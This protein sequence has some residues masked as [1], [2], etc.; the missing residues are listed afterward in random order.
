MKKLPLFGGGG[1][2]LV[3]LLF[4]VFEVFEDR[5]MFSV[6]KF[7]SG[8]LGARI[9]G[10]PEAEHR[11]GYWAATLYSS[12]HQYSHALA[13]AKRCLARKH[14]KQVREICFVVAM[15]SA[16]ELG[17]LDDVF[18][19]GAA[20]ISEMPREPM[21][22][23][24]LAEA[25][26][27]RGD[28]GGAIDL[29]MGALKLQPD[30]ATRYHI[31]YNLGEYLLAAKRD[32]AIAH[33]QEASKFVG[34]SY[35]EAAKAYLAMFEKDYGKAEMHARAAVELAEADPFRR[36]SKELFA[37]GLSLEAQGNG[38]EALVQYERLGEILPAYTETH[39]RAALVA[40]AVRRD[41]EARE[42][43]VRALDMN[44]RHPKA[45]QLTAIAG[46]AR[47]GQGPRGGQGRWG[48]VDP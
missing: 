30:K 38:A 14:D 34:H 28:L 40:A 16:M 6:M 26:Y 29:A 1:L 46:R 33:F 20:A 41:L 35:G 47:G 25:R 15:N 10:N 17:K 42:H 3:M 5:I 18:E 37:L 23:M 48:R 13:L 8:H 19:I 43:A 31:H 22:P 4:I 45:A 36:L 7:G 21:I 27:H 12:T 24:A 11:F 32:G 2:L 44:P 39:V 9:Q